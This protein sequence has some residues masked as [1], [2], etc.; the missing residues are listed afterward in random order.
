LILGV[1][2]LIA[3]KRWDRLLKVAQELKRRGLPCRLQIAG[4][5]PLRHPLQELA[6]QLGVADTTLFPGYQTDVPG[7]IGRAR[8]LVHTSDAEGTPNAVMEAMASGRPVV[9]T[10]AGDTARLIENGKTGF[11]VGRDD[12]DGLLQRVIEVITDDAL[13]TRLGQAARAHARRAFDLSRLL[14]ET[15]TA[16]EAAGWR[17]GPEADWLPGAR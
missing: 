11:I 9:A 1:G 12:A 17:S 6:A 4:D 14:R 2:A 10:A 7:L 15:L 5:G 13:A 8:L 3:G 16:Y